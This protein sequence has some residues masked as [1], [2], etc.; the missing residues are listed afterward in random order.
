VVPDITQAQIRQIYDDFAHCR[1]DRL[2]AAFHANIDF[3]SHAPA[4]LFPYLGHRR[5]WGEVASAISKV[6]EQVE[7]LEFWPLTVLVED[8]K[9]A[10]TVF[11]QFKRRSDSAKVACL[12]AH[13]LRFRD[14]RVSEFC[15]I[16]DAVDAMRQLGLLQSN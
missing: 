8:D 13:F 12:G 4:E 11:I 15:S 2:S 1:L 9:A 7:V 10:L 6:H 3:I 5:G 14:G 16:I